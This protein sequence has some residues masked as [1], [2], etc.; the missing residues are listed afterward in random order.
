M[1]ATDWL[2]MI[3][4]I[5]RVGISGAAVIA[6]HK[7]SHGGVASII[8]QGIDNGVARTAI[9]AIGKRVLIVAILW[10]VYVIETILANT[11]VGRNGHVGGF[12]DT[13]LTFNNAKAA[14]FT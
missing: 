2:G 9:G 8:R 7:V 3:A 11:F 6:H 1:W 12:T 4:P 10:I 5:E 14:K 13:I